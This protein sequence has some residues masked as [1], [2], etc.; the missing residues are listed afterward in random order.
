[1]N[2]RQLQDLLARL[3]LHPSR[4]LGQNFLLDG[5]LLD[6]IVNDGTP[7]QDELILEVGPGTGA[8]TERLLLHGTQVVAVELDVRLHAYLAER[9]KGEDRLTLLLGDACRVDLTPYLAGKPWAMIAN[10]PYSASSVLIARVL[11]FNPPPGRMLV[12]L[13]QEMAE[14]LASKPGTKDYGALSV[15]VQNSY[16]AK[17]VRRV[18]PPVFFPQPEVSSAVLRL[19]RR[20]DAPTP[21]LQARLRAVAR[22][23]FA[24]RRKQLGRLLTM[25]F[26]RVAWE[27]VLASRGHLPSVRA[28][29]LTPADF[30]ALATCLAE[31]PPEV[32]ADPEV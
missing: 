5:N 15:L 18:P 28:E 3:E 12:L 24:Q 8:L 26:P 14:R 25:A 27:P 9:F 19:L 23:G 30:L 11:T 22:A 6:A 10:L 1:V 21:E 32:A 20:S 13:Q 31:L 29:Q 2:R 17:I 4:R 16:E 7:Q